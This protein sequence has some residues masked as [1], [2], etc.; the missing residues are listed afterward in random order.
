[1][2]ELLSSAFVQGLTH[3]DGD[4]STEAY[5]N[6]LHYSSNMT[7]EHSNIGVDVPDFDEVSDEVYEFRQERLQQDISHDPAFEVSTYVRESNPEKAFIRVPRNSALR[8]VPET[9]RIE[10]PSGLV[11]FIDQTDEWET[12]INAEPANYSEHLKYFQ[13]ANEVLQE[14]SIETAT[15]LEADVREPS[16]NEVLTQYEQNG[17][18]GYIATEQERTEKGE[19]K[20]FEG[21]SYDASTNTFQPYAGSTMP[22]VPDKEAEERKTELEA[23]LEGTGLLK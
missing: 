2:S 5:L 19:Y 1:M 21:A 6:L 23:A 4:F 18:N 3:F 7:E 20:F 15:K 8:M 14:S 16:I 11:E 9:G 17:L 12:T 13:E 22:S 10:D